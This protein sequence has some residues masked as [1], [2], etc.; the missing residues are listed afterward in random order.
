MSEQHKELVRRFY[1]EVENELK[2]DV[3]DELVHPDFKDVYNTVAPFPVVGV[4]G[5]KDLAAA[6]HERLDSEIVIED[7]VAEGDRVVA[8]I[9]SRPRGPEGGAGDESNAIHG[10]EIFRVAEGKLI[11]RWVF[12]DLLPM[13]RKQGTLP[14]QHA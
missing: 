11:E 12:I 4:Q 13:L 5:I 9:T 7:L 10:V 2:L 1:G 3:A 8:R 6:L 14:P